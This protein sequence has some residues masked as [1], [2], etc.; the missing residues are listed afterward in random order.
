M[1]RSPQHKALFPDLCQ[2]GVWETLIEELVTS[3]GGRTLQYNSTLEAV[4]ISRHTTE[5]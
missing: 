5:R 1:A 3:L 4:L 2:F